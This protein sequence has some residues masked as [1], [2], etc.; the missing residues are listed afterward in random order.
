MDASIAQ[1]LQSSLEHAIQKRFGSEEMA[2]A[3]YIVVMIQNGKDAPAVT[4]EL[5]DLMATYDPSFTDFIFGEVARLP[6]PPVA[7][8]ATAAPESIKTEEVADTDM[9]E[10]KKPAGGVGMGYPD[11][12]AYAN[13]RQTLERNSQERPRGRPE[14]DGVRHSPY[15]APTGPKGEH[16]RHGSGPIRTG[17]RPMQAPPIMPVNMA[18]MLPEGFP[19]P[20]PEFFAQIAQQMALQ[21]S[22]PQRKFRTTRCAAWPECRK[23]ESCT[24]AHPTTYCTREHCARDPGFCP[25]LHPDEGINLEEAVKKQTKMDADVTSGLVPRHV[26]QAAQGA[27]YGH[28]PRTPRVPKQDDGS[29]PICRWAEQCTNRTCGFTHPSPASKDGS[30]IVLD[31]A[32]CEAGKDCTDAQCNKGHPSPSLNYMQSDTAA[33][34]CKFQPCMNPNCRFAHAP[35]QKGTAKPAPLYNGGFGNKVWTA[36]SAPSAT[37]E[38][39][40]VEGEASEKLAAVKDTEMT[41]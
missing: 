23:A 14:V 41:L 26:P 21:Q 32:W 37:A 12:R 13:V 15:G 11:K 18:G 38:R 3:E 22:Q 33:K 2:L 19:M 9:S 24:F 35:G 29:T 7:A 27:S 16:A 40:F 1:A 8:P 17:R 4:A 10:T 28:Q 39:A 20:P 30:S 36:A 34:A 6:V 5:S 25:K 31:S